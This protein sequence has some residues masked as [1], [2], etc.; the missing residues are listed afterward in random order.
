MK[1][2]LCFLLL[3]IAVLGIISASAPNPDEKAKSER[4]EYRTTSLVTEPSP[5][6]IQRQ[7]NTVR[8]SKSPDEGSGMNLMITFNGTKIIEPT[9]SHFSF[10]RTDRKPNA[11]ILTHLQMHNLG[12]E[13]IRL[14][15]MKQ[16]GLQEDYNRK[17]EKAITTSTDE[18]SFECCGC[19]LCV[20]PNEQKEKSEQQTTIVDKSEKYQTE[21]SCSIIPDGTIN[22]II[23]T[24]SNGKPII[25]QKTSCPPNANYNPAKGNFHNNIDLGP[26]Q[27]EYHGFIPC[28]DIAQ[29]FHMNAI[30]QEHL[31][32]SFLKDRNDNPILLSSYKT[33][34]A[35]TP[36]FVAENV[37]ARIK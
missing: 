27:I 35:K 1:I 21:Y 33:F 34:V 36:E 30:A 14:G 28:K 6:T 29:I 19:A 23:K 9:N 8:A 25:S 16:I 17:S 11:K 5:G 15:F 31:I 24:F 22:R 32:L 18:S 12:K 3:G 7:L 10:K 13:M 20:K 26:S 2:K 37:E 4:I